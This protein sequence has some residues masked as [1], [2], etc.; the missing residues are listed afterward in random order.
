MSVKI[1]VVVR[2][3]FRSH[4]TLK[5]SQLSQ[6]ILAT[7]CTKFFQCL[8]ISKIFQKDNRMERNGR[9]YGWCYQK[10]GEKSEEFFYRFFCVC[11]C[12][13]VT[14]LFSVVWGEFVDPPPPPPTTFFVSHLCFILWSLF[15]KTP[16]N[17]D[18]NFRLNSIHF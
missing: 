13:C 17:V 6:K 14:L 3:N 1:K 8:K 12:V 15:R 5:F 16:A 18:L 10:I 11:V 9:Y 4:R 2:S 7:N